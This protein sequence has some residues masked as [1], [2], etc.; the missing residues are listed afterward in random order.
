MENHGQGDAP[1]DTRSQAYSERLRALQGAWWKR[2]LHVQAPYR[3]NMRRSLG[4]AR[5]LDL[6]CGVGRNLGALGDRSVGIDHN[7]N[8]V[9]FCR[10]RGLTAYTPAEFHTWA[11]SEGAEFEGLL[12]A[13]VLEHLSP[14]TQSPLLAEYLPYLRPGSVVMLVC[15]QERGY[16]SDSSHVDFVDSDRL[17]AICAGLGLDVATSRSFPFP[18]RLGTRFVYNEFVVVARTPASTRTDG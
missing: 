17:L 11:R 3:W 8:S 1:M 10:S 15:P 16:A 2:A 14:E 13:H 12:V 7:A 18:R 4:A 5:T 9:A 6:G